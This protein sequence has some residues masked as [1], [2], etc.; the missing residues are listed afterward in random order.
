MSYTVNSNHR[1]ALFST[2]LCMVAGRLSLFY[3]VQVEGTFRYN[4]YHHSIC[5]FNCPKYQTILLQTTYIDWQR[6]RSVVADIS[7]R[8]VAWRI[9]YEQ[10]LLYIPG[11]YLENELTL[12]IYMMRLK[13]QTGKIC[14]TFVPGIR[15]ALPGNLRAWYPSPPPFPLYFIYVGLASVGNATVKH[16]AQYVS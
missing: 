9:A 14:F 1:Y 16:A 13:K 10:L 4:L 7:H 12:I 3:I 2:Y 6:C 5:P 15:S 11:I 8:Q